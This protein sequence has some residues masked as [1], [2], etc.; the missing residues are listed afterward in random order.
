MPRKMIG[1]RGAR[2]GAGR[3]R[4]RPSAGRGRARARPGARAR[5]TTTSRPL[6]LVSSRS[7]A[8]SQL[9]AWV[10]KADARLRNQTRRRGNNVGA[11]RPGANVGGV[12]APGRTPMREQLKSVGLTASGMRDRFTPSAAAPKAAT[13]SRTGAAGPKRSGAGRGRSRGVSPARR[14]ARQQARTNRQITRPLPAGSGKMPD[15]SPVKSR[16]YRKGGSVKKK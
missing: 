4:A 6:P 2:P 14:A 1:R 11:R 13:R 8:S 12:G 7:G 3:G 5:A 16:V 9:P 10:G 15:K